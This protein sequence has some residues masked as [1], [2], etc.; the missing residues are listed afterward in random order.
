[1]YQLL[2]GAVLWGASI[3]GAGWWA[4]E[5]GRDTELAAQYR[6]SAA[7]EKA[8]TAATL[9]AAEA[10]SKIEV[11]HVT[12]RQLLEREIQTREV[13]RDCRS[14]DDAVRLL[15]ASPGIAQAASAPGGGELPPA[16]TPR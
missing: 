6:E 3:A 1:M 11:K 12:Q 13:F 9:A 7:A 2:I 10:I 16:P 15:N 8:S 14:G 4:Y 5:R